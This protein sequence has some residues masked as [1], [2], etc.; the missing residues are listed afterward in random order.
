MKQTGKILLMALCCAALPA[1]GQGT[2]S[3]E[4]WQV[5]SSMQMAGMSM[6]AMST[7][8]CKQPGDDSVPMK[9]E[10]NCEV[11]DVKRSGNTQSFKM[12][13][14]GKEAVAGSGEFTYLGADHYKGTMQMS[15]QGQQMTMSMEGRK[16]GACDGKEIN[17]QAKQMAATV[18]AR[19]EAV[20]AQS[21][22]AMAAACSKMATDPGTTAQLLQQGCK[23]PKDRAAFCTTFQTHDGFGR[24]AKLQADVAA[25][26]SAGNAL[27]DHPLDDAGKLCGVDISATQAKL[28]VSA[29][30]AGKLGFLAER[31]P[32][33]AQALAKAQCAG[34]DYTSLPQKYRDFC[35]SYAARLGSAAADPGAAK[36]A[37]QPSAKDKAK[38]ALKSLGGLLGGGN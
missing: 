17:L 10:K 27:G 34:R 33:Q 24:Q 35:T 26:P 18:Q 19:S 8:V 21:T 31:C 16:L 25:N 15:M 4:K 38:N 30:G 2:P 14:T 12:R 6:P 7:E 1:L 20:Q 13:C 36:P 32:T 23:D 9:T 37:E 29:E 22:A 3:G 5:S 11:Y 28:C